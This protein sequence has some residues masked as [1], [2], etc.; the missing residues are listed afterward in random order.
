M[1]PV[2]ARSPVVSLQRDLWDTWSRVSLRLDYVLRLC[3]RTRRR[4]F[5]RFFATRAAAACCANPRRNATHVNPTS[6]ADCRVLVLNA[7]AIRARRPGT[8][9]PGM[10]AVYRRRARAASAALLPACSLRATCSCSFARAPATP[11][12]MSALLISAGAL[13]HCTKAPAPAGLSAR[14]VRATR[15]CAHL[16]GCQRAAAPFAQ[17]PRRDAGLRA[18]AVRGSP[19]LVSRPAPPASL[20]PARCAAPPRGRWP[21]GRSGWRCALAGGAGGAPQ[22][23]SACAHLALRCACFRRPADAPRSPRAPRRVRPQVQAKGKKAGRAGSGNLNARQQCVPPAHNLPPSPPLR[24]C[25]GDASTFIVIRAG[26]R[27]HCG[28]NSLTDTRRRA[29]LLFPAPWSTG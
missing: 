6:S 3:S 9:C 5:S 29:A 21:P 7:Q 10:P 15:R 22:R 26:A 18:S 20:A 24:R 8:L 11:A 14:C 1:R 4:S 27:R 23:G 25:V 19:R 28:H 16:R 17:Q 12:T 13:G 2:P